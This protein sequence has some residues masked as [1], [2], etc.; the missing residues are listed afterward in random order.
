MLNGWEIIEEDTANFQ[1][2]LFSPTRG[3][4]TEKSRVASIKIKIKLKI[5]NIF[6]RYIGNDYLN[7]V[8]MYLFCTCTF[9]TA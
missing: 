7:I 1:F 2:A 5:N 4:S 9:N 8:M 6:F 3:T